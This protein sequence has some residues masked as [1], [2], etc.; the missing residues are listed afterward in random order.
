[1]ITFQEHIKISKHL[2]DKGNLK[3]YVE[4]QKPEKKIILLRDIAETYPLDNNIETDLST[5]KNFKI[6]KDIN[7]LVLG[8]FIMIEQIIT[9]KHNFKY[10]VENDLEI[11]KLLIRPSSHDVFDNQDPEVERVNEENILKASVKDVYQILQSFLDVRE[12]VLFEQF[13]GVFYEVKEDSED[14]D[15]EDDSPNDSSEA[16]FQQQW[17]WY[18]M[19]RMLAKEDIT[20]YDEIYMLNMSTVMPEMSFLAQKNKIDSARAREQNALS[21]L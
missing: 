5:L 18:S 20:K 7:S 8:Q 11:A 1:M 21:K 9:G 15:D 13:K 12:F 19:V 14:E 17:Y 4:Q 16:L 2:Q 10:D 6:H 3:S